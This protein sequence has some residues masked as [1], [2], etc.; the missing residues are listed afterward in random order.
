M[1]WKMAQAAALGLSLVVGCADGAPP[2]IVRP[3][4]T[5]PTT[6]T[7]D[8]GAV[9]QRPQRPMP[10]EPT[11]EFPY[12]GIFNGYVQA[13]REEQVDEEWAK[14]TEAT[15]KNQLTALDPNVVRVRL[16]ECRCGLCAL[17]YIIA[18]GGEGANP[19][20][21][22]DLPAVRWS[23]YEKH[24][25][26][27]RADGWVEVLGLLGRHPKDSTA[28]SPRV[29]SSDSPWLDPACEGARPFPPTWDTGG[30]LNW[31]GVGINRMYLSMAS[32]KVCP[33]LCG[34]VQP[35]AHPGCRYHSDGFVYCGLTKFTPR[36]L[37]IIEGDWS[38]KRTEPGASQ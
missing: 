4:P 3:T 10:P 8:A 27:L 34:K 32:D 18:P 28:S 24:M 14:A 11:A 12:V 1:W 29:R 16:L 5:A 23:G 30:K 37:P 13:F 19:Q 7:P 33:C 9:A 20:P 31:S 36:G 38:C 22:V 26:G 15:L 17:G 35:N 6:P 21:G 25:R 2:R